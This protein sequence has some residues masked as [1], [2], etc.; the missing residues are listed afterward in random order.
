MMMKNDTHKLVNVALFSGLAFILQYFDFPIIFLFPQYLKFDFSDLVAII[1]GFATGPIGV[2]F[3][4][5]IK[6][7]LHFIT[8]STTGGVGEVANFVAGV[9]L[10]LPVVVAYQYR[11]TRW[12]VGIGFLLAGVAMCLVTGFFNYYVSLPI[13]VPGLSSQTYITMIYTIFTPFNIVKTGVLAV[14]LLVLYQPI[15]FFVDWLERVG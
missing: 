11:K 1:G 15:R 4:Q 13:F 2:I 12:S 9:S 6:N 8:H 7:L 10:A 5:L 14:I 3:I